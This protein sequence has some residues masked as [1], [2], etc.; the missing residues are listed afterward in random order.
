MSHPS[1]P[2][3]SQLPEEN[4]VQ[5]LI[6]RLK[7]DG[8]AAGQQQA[9]AVIEEAHAKARKILSEAQQEAKHIRQRAL[10]EAIQDKSAG[11]EALRLASRDVLIEL[12][13]QISGLFQELLSRK[14]NTKFNDQE[15]LQQLLMEICRQQMQSVSPGQRIEILASDAETINAQGAETPLAHLI[16]SLTQEGIKQGVSFAPT[17]EP[18]S[19]FKVHVEGEQVTIDLTDQA[20]AMLLKQHLLPRFRD[21]LEGYI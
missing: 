7:N 3:T 19:G 14:V 12:R 18:F 21:V 10:E 16:L 13:N 15:F 4:G 2:L 9:R 11:Q 17:Q 20:V 5:S 1:R 8:L 6:D